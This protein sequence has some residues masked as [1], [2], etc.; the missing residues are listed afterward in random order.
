MTSAVAASPR[1]RSTTAGGMDTLGSRQRALAA[2][3]RTS[4]R[5]VVGLE[6]GAGRVTVL[7]LDR[8]A[9]ALRCEIRDLISD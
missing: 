6:R 3:A 2:A 8:L 5:Y 1:K 7:D 4:Q 9:T